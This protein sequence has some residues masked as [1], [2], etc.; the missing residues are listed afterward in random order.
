MNLAE[1]IRSTKGRRTY[2]QISLDCGGVPTSQRI[3]QIANGKPLKTF[4][5]TDTIRALA[6]GLH[7]GEHTVVAAAAESLGLESGPTTGL[8]ALLP[9][10]A[11]ALT[12]RQVATILQLVAVMNDV[13]PASQE[14]DGH[15]KPTPT[16]T[17]ARARVVT[18]AEVRRIE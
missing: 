2:D 1:L 12:E 14:S 18:N 16:K 11:D 8:A 10:S 5:D 13:E 4:P 9:P 17:R 6:R 7:V 3:Q 15:G